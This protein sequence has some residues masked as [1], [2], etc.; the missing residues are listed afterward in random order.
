MF[1]APRRPSQRIWRFSPPLTPIRSQAPTFPDH[2]QIDVRGALEDVTDRAPVVVE[3]VAFSNHI[4]TD[5]EQALQRFGGFL[6]ADLS[7]S[8]PDRPY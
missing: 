4:V 3:L 2:L 5:R 7:W 8:E 1:K 6:A